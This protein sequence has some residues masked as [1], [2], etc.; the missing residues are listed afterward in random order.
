VITEVVDVLSEELTRQ[1]EE[2]EDLDLDEK[3]TG[4]NLEK[5]C[6]SS[7]L[8]FVPYITEFTDFSPKDNTLNLPEVNPIIHNLWLSFLKTSRISYY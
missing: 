1:A 6:T 5:S 4:D 2:S 7:H 3:I 8:Q